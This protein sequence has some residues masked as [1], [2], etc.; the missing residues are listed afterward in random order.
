MFCWKGLLRL[1]L[2]DAGWLLLASKPRL[3]IQFTYQETETP[4][5]GTRS[6]GSK[7]S[8]RTAYPFSSSL[9]FTAAIQ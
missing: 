6:W 7:N 5:L 2:L 1:Q 8:S 4:L 9:V 3:P